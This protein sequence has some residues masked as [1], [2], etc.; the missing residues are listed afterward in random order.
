MTKVIDFEE[1]SFCGNLK[2]KA[3]KNT[4]NLSYRTIRDNNRP[5]HYRNVFDDIKTLY[6]KAHSVQSI[7]I[8][9]ECIESETETDKEYD[10]IEQRYENKKSAIIFNFYK[11]RFLENVK[12]LMNHLPNDCLSYR[13]KVWIMAS[14]AFFQKK[15]EHESEIWSDTFG[16][17]YY[18]SVQIQALEC[19]YPSAAM[20]L[21]ILFFMRKEAGYF[22]SI[23]LSTSYLGNVSNTSENCQLKSLIHIA[24]KQSVDFGIITG[25]QRID[26]SAFSFFDALINCL[27]FKL[28]NGNTNYFQE[29]W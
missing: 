11:D 18:E 5:S 8:L 23:S 25:W 10:E 17:V 13:F 9:I 28:Q 15:A 20:N 29:L 6:F 27:D 22:M 1:K 26:L 16:Y 7:S 4:I 3:A 14:S 24:S 2:T 21:T 12:K 19:T